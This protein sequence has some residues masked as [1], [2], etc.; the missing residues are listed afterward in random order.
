MD[1]MCNNNGNGITSVR[2]VSDVATTVVETPS[3]L[4]SAGSVDENTE[5]K[6]CDD[7]ENESHIPRLAPTT[8]PT[9][10]AP[11]VSKKALKFLG[12]GSEQVARA[13]ALK[14]LGLTESELYWADPLFESPEQRN[15]AQIAFEK[16]GYSPKLL[17]LTGMT[18]SQILRRKALVCLGVTEQMLDAEREKKML[19]AFGGG[20]GSSRDS[21][22]TSECHSHA[23][24]FGV[25]PPMLP[26]FSPLRTARASVTSV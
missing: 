13:K 17:S 12:A 21:R 1:N 26:P 10:T 25:K 14:Q 15:K 3:S 22:S 8:V 2:S 5:T 24:L 4:S 23:C 16:R 6:L 9:H 18:E 20:G 11:T 19:A 7:K